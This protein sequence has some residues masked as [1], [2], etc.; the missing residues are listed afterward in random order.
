MISS[1]EFDDLIVKELASERTRAD[2]LELCRVFQ[3][4]TNIVIITAEIFLEAD[5]LKMISA[6]AVMFLAGQRYQKGITE[7]E[8]L[9]KMFKQG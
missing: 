1:K 5:P 6:L 4:N 3:G 8:M 2:I 7:Q 9:E